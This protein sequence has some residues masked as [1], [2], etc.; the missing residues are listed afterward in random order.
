LSLLLCVYRSSIPCCDTKLSQIV[1]GQ[2]RQV[3]G[4]QRC[5]SSV[6]TR[7]HDRLM[8]FCE[9]V[10]SCDKLNREELREITCDVENIILEHQKSNYLSIIFLLI[11]KYLIR[12]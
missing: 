6:C 3:R 2:V 4:L 8:N 5:C 9:K 10:H 11:L 12:L 7:K 1:D